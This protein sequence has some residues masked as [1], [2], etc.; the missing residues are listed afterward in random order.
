MSTTRVAAMPKEEIWKQLNAEL[1]LTPSR[2]RVTISPL[3]CVASFTIC[4]FIKL[5]FS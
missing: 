1:G 2:L 4:G 3:I 5:A